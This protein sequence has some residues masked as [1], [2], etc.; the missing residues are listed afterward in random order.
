MPVRCPALLRWPSSAHPP[1]PRETNDSRCDAIQFVRDISLATN[2]NSISRQS[3]LAGAQPLPAPLLRSVIQFTLQFSLVGARARSTKCFS[4]ALLCIGSDSIK[5]QTRNMHCMRGE[6]F[7]CRSACT[8][9]AAVALARAAG[10][11]TGI[12]YALGTSWEMCSF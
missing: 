12:P 2:Y 8:H 1:R 10:V 9:G 5:R 7:V 11:T 6:M 3:V 4:M